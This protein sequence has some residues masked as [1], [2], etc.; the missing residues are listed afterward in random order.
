MASSR[1]TAWREGLDDELK[2]GTKRQKDCNNIRREKIAPP[3]ILCRC[4]C[5]RSFKHVACLARV[6]SCFS[7]LK[8]EL[9]CRRPYAISRLPS[10]LLFLHCRRFFHYFSAWGIVPSASSAERHSLRT[11]GTGCPA[12]RRALRISDRRCPSALRCA[13]LCSS[14]RMPFNSAST[15][16][17]AL[18]TPCT[19]FGGLPC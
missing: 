16:L 2:E 5:S 14:C 13:V 9:G 18:F 7:F 10:V 3:S 11:T 6:R 8:H 12:E 1:A 17:C 4:G 15:I 19:F